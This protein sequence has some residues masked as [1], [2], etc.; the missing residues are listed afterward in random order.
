MIAPSSAEAVRSAGGYLCDRALAGWNVTVLTA[1]R[2]DR[3]LRILGARRADLELALA[4]PVRPRPHAVA[5]DARCY[6]LDPRV[7]SIVQAALNDSAEVRL[8]GDLGGGL[9][10]AGSEAPQPVPHRLSLAA[11]AFK[12]HAL[13]AVAS[14]G[15]LDDGGATEMFQTS[16][17][18]RT[19][20]TGRE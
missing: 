3:P 9:D 8:W 11:R 19:P 13:A 7:R 12:T 16:D 20:A 14:P 17:L 1:D 10:L 4:A 5:V 15:D 6:G 18:Q 2:A